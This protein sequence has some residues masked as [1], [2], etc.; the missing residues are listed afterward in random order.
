MKTLKT[1][2]EKTLLVLGSLLVLLLWSALVLALW[3]KLAIAQQVTHEV[4]EAD[5]DAAKAKIEAAQKSL[6][7]GEAQISVSPNLEALPQPVKAAAGNSG[8]PVDIEALARQF[9]RQGNRRAA[10]Q[11][12]SPHLLAFVSFSIPLVTLQRMA[13]DAEHTHTTFVLRGMIHQDMQETMKAVKAVIGKRKVGWFIDPDAFTRFDVTAV[14]SYVLFKRDAVTRNC[15]GTQCF[16]DGDF[17]KVSGDVSIGYALD[18]IES[19]LPLYRDVVAAV[20]KGS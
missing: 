10:A 16:A 18:Q 11:N 15:G 3:S 8:A 6:E 12:T 1:R 17:A 4:T 13:A 9:D 2:M 20:R 5:L 14:P 7:R 19:Q